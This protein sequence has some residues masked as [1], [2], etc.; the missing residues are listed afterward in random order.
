MK[1]VDLPSQVC[2]SNRFDVLA[3]QQADHFQTPA[4]STGSMEP[5]DLPSQVCL[6]V[7]CQKKLISMKYL[8]CPRSISGKH[9]NVLSQIAGPCALH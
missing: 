6:I 3:D 8:A 1:P 2:L 4:I 5:A 7:S 9:W